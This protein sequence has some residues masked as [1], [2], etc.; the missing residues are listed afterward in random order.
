[1]VRREDAQRVGGYNGER[2]GAL[3]D[4]ANWAQ[5]ALGYE[6]VSC[7]HEPLVRN[8]VHPASSTGRQ[9]C[10]DWHRWG[11]TMYADLYDSLHRH[12]KSEKELRSMKQNL[13]AAFTATILLPNVGQ[14]G[15][16]PYA[17]R[18]MLRSWRY[19]LRLS[20]AQRFARQAWKVA[21]FWGRSRAA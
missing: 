14:P 21:R 18:E 5:V 10:R 6:A 19:F 20:V 13:L 17:S 4:T 9:S 2:Y 3:C 1:M 12:G 11:E 8:M 16:I 7:I 15:W